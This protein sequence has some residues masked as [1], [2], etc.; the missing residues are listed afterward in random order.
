[1]CRQLSV[2]EDFLEDIT[3]ALKQPL[4]R[5]WKR[6]FPRITAAKCC[7]H[8]HSCLILYDPMDYS[9]PG[10][11]THGIFQAR[12]LKWVAISSSRG[13]SQPRD[14]TWVSCIAGGFFT[15]ELPG[16][17]WHVGKFWSVALGWYTQAAA[18]RMAHVGCLL[19]PQVKSWTQIH[20][21]NLHRKSAV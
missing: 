7:M 14:Q 13:S 17:C 5:R 3:V 21:C 19:M 4:A 11:S 16:K 15:T 10:S 8:A 12:I 18:E 20:P 9:P 6:P 2:T 1:M